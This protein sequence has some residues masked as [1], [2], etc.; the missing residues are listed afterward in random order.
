MTVTL[1][2]ILDVT[3]C[4]LLDKKS[5]T[6]IYKF[7]IPEDGSNRLCKNVRVYEPGC[8]LSHSRK[9]YSSTFYLPVFK[10]L[11]WSKIVLSLQC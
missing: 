9:Q 6:S 2:I 8:M 5:A 4:C 10:I 11:S 7:F 3:P 1:K